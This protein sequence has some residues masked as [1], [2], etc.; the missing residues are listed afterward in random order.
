MVTSAQAFLQTSFLAV[1]AKGGPVMV[2]L[3]AA[4]VVSLTVIIERCCFWRR[5]R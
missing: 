5:L 3:L 4:S 2:P 1:L